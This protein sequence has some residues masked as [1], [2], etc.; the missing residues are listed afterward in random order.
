R[1]GREDQ[2]EAGSPLTEQ[3]V[4]RRPTRDAERAEKRAKAQ[5]RAKAERPAKAPRAPVAPRAERTS[6]RKPSFLRE[7]VVLVVSALLIAVGVKAFVAQAFFIPSGSM[8]PQLQVGDRI[9]VS[10]VSY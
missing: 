6:D 7:L 9:V 8:L 1:A 10:K 4:T 5:K 3:A 2:G